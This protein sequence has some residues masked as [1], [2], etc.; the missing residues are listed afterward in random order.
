[1]YKPMNGERGDGGP[2]FGGIINAV[3]AEKGTA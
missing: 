2:V 3:Q 1:M